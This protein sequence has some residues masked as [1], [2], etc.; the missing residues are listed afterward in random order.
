MASMSL[1]PP[2]LDSSMPAFNYQKACPIEFS[3][4]KF[5]ALSDIKSVQIS[6]AYQKS[7]MNAVAK[8]NTDSRNRES[9]IIIINMDNIKGLGAYK[10]N[11]DNLNLYAISINPD[12]IKGGW[13]DGEIYKVQI[14]FSA[15][16]Y[17]GSMPE[18]WL[19]DNA[20]SF[21][22]WSTVCAIKPISDV[23]ITIPVFNYDTTTKN[24]DTNSTKE[25]S[26]YSTTLDFYGSYYCKTKNET[27][28][29]YELILYDEL[30]EVVERSGI[31]Y[32]NEY[33]DSNQFKY[34][35]A[36]E[37]LNGINY[38]L[39]FT[40]YSEHGYTETLKFNFFI[41]TDAKVRP[42]FSIITIENDIYDIFKDT[43]SLETEEE[44]GRIG[45]K[46]FDSQ[47]RAYSGNICIRRTDSKSNFTKWEDIQVLVFK[48]ELINSKEPF[49]DYT[50]ESGV[51]YQYGLQELTITANGDIQRSDLTP[52][53]P[54]IRNFNYSYLL[55]ANGVQLKLKYNNDMGSYKINVNEGKIDTIGGVYPFITRNG[56][57]NYRTFPINGLISFNMD[58][59]N[60]FSTKKEI[61]GDETV[62]N[63]IIGYYNT[64][65][66]KNNIIQ[67][68]YIYERFFR[69]KVL[70]FLYDG[71]PKLFKSTTEGNIIVRLMDI[72][73]SPQ[74]NLG[75]MIYSFSSTGH[76][77]AEASMENY[78]KYNFV[79]IAEPEQSFAVYQQNVGQII[80][81]FVVNGDNP[82]NICQKIWEKYDSQGKNYA[83]YS[84][85]LGKI[86]YLRI[87]INSQPFRITNNS[88]S[89]NQ[90]IEQDYTVGNKINY[91]GNTIV[92]YGD[93]RVYEFDSMMSFTKDDIISFLAPDDPSMTQGNDDIPITVNATID[94][95]YEV[96]KDIYVA[97]QVL[98]YEYSS[99]IGQY[100]ENTI[101]GNSIYSLLFYKYYIEWDNKFSRLGR[102]T[103]IEIEASPGAVFY[104][105]DT[106][107]L[108]NEYHDIG[109]TGVLRIQNL[110]DIK[111]L[112]FLGFRQSDG[113]ILDKTYLK[114][115]THK[116]GVTEDIYQ[117]V[118]TDILIN[119]TYIL[120]KGD[121]VQ[122]V[123]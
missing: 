24:E 63:K 35:F 73:T 49:F 93:K 45:I 102:L 117:S 58:E 22:E 122:D 42:D 98:K 112:K 94:F 71:K 91:N 64:Y 46:V 88:Q 92:V 31:L 38:K 108:N 100:Y 70:K 4:S 62:D 55:G 79:H 78:L 10:V 61:Y 111:E 75:R 13:A 50:I 23:I 44:E 121:Y 116:D 21:S 12:D 59:M 114:T 81:D 17:D 89:S 86:K 3:L 15:V 83:G 26:L 16:S 51:W 29:S 5:N 33:N 6:V 52:S 99:G 9:G 104:I 66:H 82:D 96:S 57:P 87:E 76:E 41:S 113:S 65:N 67:Y 120:T 7:G 101:A 1:Y 47:Q 118:S 48:Q 56:N 54:I 84:Y 95:V 30:N 8:S 74:Q 53:E 77:V 68:D 37:L 97:K 69:E 119:Y 34:L 32:T 20:N 40:Y 105:K 11:K 109:Y 39:Y 107:D 123:K 28:Y 60:T 115:I 106:G 72:N 43:S 14:R 19:H 90:N 18:Q 85:T 27:L 36:T 110:S 25:N 103:S 80:G 2:I